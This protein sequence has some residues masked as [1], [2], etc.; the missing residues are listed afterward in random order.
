MKGIV[1]TGTGDVTQRGC[2]W[3]SDY[4]ELDGWSSR[5]CDLIEDPESWRFVED[6]VPRV[7]YEPR[8]LCKQL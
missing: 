2:F 5:L 7:P 6:L 4:P 1:S 3:R 8:N